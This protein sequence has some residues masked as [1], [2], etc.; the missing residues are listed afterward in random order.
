MAM[1]DLVFDVDGVDGI[2]TYEKFMLHYNFPPYCVGEI[3]WLKAPGRRELGHG[4]LA[5][6]AIVNM[7]DGLEDYPY[8]VR[9]VS[10]IILYFQH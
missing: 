7:I 5:Y 9:I 2:A 1:G 6:R 10:E 3:G 4:K 8:S